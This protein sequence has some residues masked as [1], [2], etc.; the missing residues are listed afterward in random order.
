[1]ARDGGDNENLFLK[2]SENTFYFF[3]QKFGNFIRHNFFFGNKINCKMCFAS[4][5]SDFPKKKHDEYVTTQFL[6]AAQNF[7]AG[8]TLD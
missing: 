3:T 5:V 6:N 7:T 4:N 2:T 1:M 8:T